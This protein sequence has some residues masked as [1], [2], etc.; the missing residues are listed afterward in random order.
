MAAK[1]TRL[2]HKISTQLHL[3][4]E[5]SSICSSRSRRKVRKLMDT[6]SHLLLSY[7]SEA[8][9]LQRVF[10]HQRNVWTTWQVARTAALCSLMYEFFCI[11]IFSYYYAMGMKPALRLA[12]VNGQ[13]SALFDCLKI[14]SNGRLWHYRCWTSLV[15][16]LV[17]LL[18][19]LLLLLRGCIQK[20]PYWPPG[21]KTANGTALCH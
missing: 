12:N 4:A 15:L 20:F 11:I 8:L 18:L 16:R 21:A 7:P 2:T 14:V 17:F 3:V 6:P 5:S 1:L 9:G 19:L 10:L 13:N